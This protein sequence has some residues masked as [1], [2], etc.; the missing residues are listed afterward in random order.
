MNQSG[1][2]TYDRILVLIVAVL[3][4][5]T[6][7]SCLKVHVDYAFGVTGEVM[8]KDG[9]PI[10]G[11]SVVI[12]IDQPVYD[13]IAPVKKAKAITGDNG[14]FQFFYIAHSSNINYSVKATKA[15]FQ[16]ISLKSSS[17]NSKPMKIIMLP[18]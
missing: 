7:V 16:E 3:I 12:S 6:P 2:Q 18:K 14:K 4:F 5:L 9:K 17:S 11:A 10:S 13:V 1:I 8:T 15:G